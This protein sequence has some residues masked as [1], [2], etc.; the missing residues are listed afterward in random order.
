[1]RANFR[2]DHELSINVLNLYST[3][4]SWKCHSFFITS[5][6]HHTAF[7]DAKVSSIDVLQEGFGALPG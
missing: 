2:E 4:L 3:C 6:P 7:A 5:K 1:M